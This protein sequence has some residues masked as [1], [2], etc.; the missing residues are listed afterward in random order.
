MRNISR[1]LLFVDIPLTEN[2]TYRCEPIQSIHTPST[3]GTPST[4]LLVKTTLTEW[5]TAMWV[6]FFGGWDER[7]SF[8]RG[9]WWE[10]L[11]W[12]ELEFTI[13]EFSG[14]F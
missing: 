4:Y 14:I 5:C 7:A 3:G 2:L 1:I 11:E 8:E 6:W 9:E 10:V 13:H 12:M